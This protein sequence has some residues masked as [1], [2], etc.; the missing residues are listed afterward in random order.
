MLVYLCRDQSL[1]QFTHFKSSFLVV[2]QY[3][4]P[5]VRVRLVF[6]KCFRFVERELAQEEDV[7]KFRCSSR[8]TWCK[9]FL[10]TVQIL[11]YNKLVCRTKLI[12]MFWN[13]NIAFIKYIKI[14]NVTKLL[15]YEIQTP[16]K[17]TK[18]GSL[19]FSVS[20]LGSFSVCSALF[21]PFTLFTDY[22]TIRVQNK[23]EVRKWFE[24]YR[25][26]RTCWTATKYFVKEKV[27]KKMCAFKNNQF[28]TALH[29]WL[30]SRL[31]DFTAF[32]PGIPQGKQWRKKRGVWQN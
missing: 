2:K 25:S 24:D 18:H 10:W 8:G 16:F 21:Y 30:Q 27:K 14:C 15:A 12:D 7:F 1:A 29:L 32:P 4:L 28:N 9:V 19:H 26:C 6:S 20:T 5:G 13:L 22:L 23:N 3:H 17:W 31:N 11:Q